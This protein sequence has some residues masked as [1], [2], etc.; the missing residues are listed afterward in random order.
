MQFFALNLHEILVTY[1]IYCDMALRYLTV[2]L[3]GIF[4]QRK[5]SERNCCRHDEERRRHIEPKPPLADVSRKIEVA[6]DRVD[7]N[8]RFAAAVDVLAFLHGVGCLSA[9]L[10]TEGSKRCHK[11]NLLRYL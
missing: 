7:G 6:A 4:S 8:L 5:L 10:A 11:T 2:C 1:V 3:F 9:C